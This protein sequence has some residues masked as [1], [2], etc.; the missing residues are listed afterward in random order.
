MTTYKANFYQTLKIKDK[1]P[2]DWNEQ[3]KNIQLTYLGDDFEIQNT[4]IIIER[5]RKDLIDR[6]IELLLTT[7]SIDYDT[8]TEEVL[9]IIYDNLI[10][11]KNIPKFCKMGVEGDEL[12]II[13]IEL[14]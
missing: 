12:K 2:K 7:D 14:R 10:G 1:L 3:V 6:N 13:E 8:D 4:S 9:D 5:R 11:L